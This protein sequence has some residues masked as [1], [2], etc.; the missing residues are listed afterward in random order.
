MGRSAKL[1]KRVK[2]TQTTQPKPAAPSP[3]SA[4]IHSAKKRAGLKGRAKTRSGAHVLGGAD[5]VTLL[6][7]GRR[8]AA[9]EALKLPAE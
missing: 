6:M 3:P 4:N 1:H 5:Y 7:S 8:K 9:G 2:K